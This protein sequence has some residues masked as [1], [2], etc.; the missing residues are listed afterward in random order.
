MAEAI[1]VEISGIVEDSAENDLA[2]DFLG[3][4]Q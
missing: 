4:F 1:W 3:H 2:K